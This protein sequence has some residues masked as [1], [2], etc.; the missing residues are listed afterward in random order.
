MDERQSEELEQLAARYNLILA[1]NGLSG[2][3][4]VSPTCSSPSFLT[5][6]FPR[7]LLFSDEAGFDALLSEIAE[8]KV[9]LGG[10]QTTTP[11]LWDPQDVPYN[12]PPALVRFFVPCLDP[13]NSTFEPERSMHQ[14]VEHL[15]TLFTLTRFLDPQDTAFVFPSTVLE[16]LGKQELDEPAAARRRRAAESGTD[17][18]HR[19]E[20]ARLAADH[21]R[22]EAELLDELSALSLGKEEAEDLAEQ[23]EGQLEQAETQL[24]A[25]DDQER[26]GP[27]QVALQARIE[28]LEAEVEKTGAA[29]QALEAQ[30]KEVNRALTESRAAAA[31]LEPDL[32]AARA[33][34][35]AAEERVLTL[36]EEG[37]RKARKME[38]LEAELET[39]KDLRRLE[40]NVSEEV[41]SGPSG[42]AEGSPPQRFKSLPTL[43]AP[44][45]AGSLPAPSPV[46]PLS[47]AP[48]SEVAAPTTYASAAH[49]RSS[50]AP[51]APPAPS[52]TA[53]LS[54]S[55][56]TL[57]ASSSSSSSTL[58]A[59]RTRT[60]S[61][62]VSAAEGS[63]TSEAH[64]RVPVAIDVPGAA[65][66]N[67]TK[68]LGFVPT[69]L[70]TLVN[71]ESTRN[72]LQCGYVK[73]EKRSIT[74]AGYETPEQYAAQLGRQ[75]SDCYIFCERMR[76]GSGG[77]VLRVWAPTKDRGKEAKGR[78]AQILKR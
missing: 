65:W 10:V 59:P 29:Y 15:W 41:A 6:C 22:V 13:T 54:P 12:L 25:V 30:L 9:D 26:E 67:D 76:D 57:V 52:A 37:A 19:A 62:T 53:S 21:A 7:R 50:T 42:T 17:Y 73:I 39:E 32:A 75:L 69:D 44:S 48:D 18:A 28:E 77:G 14:N 24:R 45:S 70:R 49:P 66:T 5:L 2:D 68:A 78:I 8:G 36:E 31:H 16:A 27:G 38:K 3:L 72:Q 63:A 1:C 40:E 46:L 60:S 35:A 71:R 56:S 23:L 61:A 51:D 4:Q 11:A 58:P 43:E 34:A 64:L 74:Q 33:R 55:A 47:Q 20:L